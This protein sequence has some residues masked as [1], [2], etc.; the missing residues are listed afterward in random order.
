MRRQ[1]EIPLDDLPLVKEFSTWVFRVLG[2]R[3]LEL[4]GLGFRGSGFR[5]RRETCCAVA[6]LVARREYGS[7]GKIEATVLK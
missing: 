5:V 1:G 7:H 3:G 6:L 2:F 4:K